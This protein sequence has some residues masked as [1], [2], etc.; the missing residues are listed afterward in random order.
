MLEDICLNHRFALPNK[1]F[2]YLMA[3]LPVLGSDL[4]E[5]SAVINTYQVG[6]TVDPSSRHNLVTALNRIVDRP[7]ERS[8]WA[9]RTPFVFE[10]Y[11]WESAARNMTSHYA[12][13]LDRMHA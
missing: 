1:L 8:E 11:G 7:Y 2:E 13:L 5:I 9:E 3:G 10:R 6:F 12:L 4:P